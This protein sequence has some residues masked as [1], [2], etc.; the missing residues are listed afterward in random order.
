MSR[1]DPIGFNSDWHPLARAQISSWKLFSS[2]RREEELSQTALVAD[3]ANRIN[4]RTLAC[5]KTNELLA[6]GS[7]SLHHTNTQL[8]VFPLRLAYN[9]NNINNSDTPVDIKELLR[10]TGSLHFIVQ[11]RVEQHRWVEF[12]LAFAK[13]CQLQFWLASGAEG[14]LCSRLWLYYKP[15]VTH[16]NMHKQIQTCNRLMG[17]YGDQSR[18]SGI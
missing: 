6:S 17:L 12:A 1:W 14:G 3:A 11:L 16:T 10:S 8:W 5:I 2:S 9:N 15:A 7:N 13:P 18:A 4:L